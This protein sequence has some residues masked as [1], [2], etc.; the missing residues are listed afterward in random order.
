[1]MVVK[2]GGNQGV[3]ADAVCADVAEL[4]KKGERIVLVHGGSHETNVL[5]EKLGKPPRFVTTASGH[6]SRYT[7]RETLE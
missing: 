7:D 5:S 4:V 2:I 1:M 6:Q 3:D